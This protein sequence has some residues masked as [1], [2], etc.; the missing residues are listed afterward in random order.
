V[1]LQCNC[2]LLFSTDPRPITASLLCTFMKTMGKVMFNH[3]CTQSVNV[4]H[5]INNEYMK[6]IEQVLFLVLKGWTSN[7]VGLVQTNFIL[8]G[9]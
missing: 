6:K 3:C 7:S 2:V 9:F 5:Y 8:G 4:L 1:I